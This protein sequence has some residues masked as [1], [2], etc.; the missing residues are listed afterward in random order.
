[1]AVRSDDMAAN[2]R[3]VFA[4]FPFRETAAIVAAAGFVG[5]LIFCLKAGM[6][7]WFAVLFFGLYFAMSVTITRIRAELGPPA[8]DLYNAGPDLL[9]TDV[10]GTRRIGGHNLSVM[11]LFFWLNHLSYRAHPMPHQ[12]EG[13]KLAHQ[14]HLNAFHLLC[15]LTVAILVGVLSAV[16]G[17][18]HISYEIGLEQAH[19]WYSH[20]AF[21]RLAGWLYNPSEANPVGLLYTVGGFT[22][23]IGLLVLRWRFIQ[24]PL[25][26]VGYVVSSWWTFTGLWFPLL[27]SWT[28]KRVLLSAGG[29]R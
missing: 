10:L 18:L 19:S 4:R 13:L 23:A 6:A 11:S 26:P 24:W 17:H 12:L 28:V 29:V 25:H 15:V 20:A 7:L 14:T 3:A 2:G 5:I 22:F 9:L 27:I 8:H 1:M 16:W 21:N